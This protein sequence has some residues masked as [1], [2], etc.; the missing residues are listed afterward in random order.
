MKHAAVTY[1]MDLSRPFLMQPG[2]LRL[3]EPFEVRARLLF[4]DRW[5]PWL[6]NLS[7]LYLNSSMSDTIILIQWLSIL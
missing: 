5:V 1:E 2:D 3:T 6:E 7:R 4:F